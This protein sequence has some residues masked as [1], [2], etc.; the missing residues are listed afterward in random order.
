MHPRN[1][2]NKGYDFT[3]LIQALP[4]LANVTRANPKGRLT[5]DFANPH[6]IK[7][8][9]R[10]LLKHHYQI[11][12]WDI[13]EG[14]LCPPIPGRVDYIHAIADLI[15]HNDNKKQTVKGL[16]IGTGA[17]I[18]YPILGQQIYG[19][20]FVATDISEVAIRSA[21]HIQA[22]NKVLTKTIDIRRQAQNNQIFKGVLNKDER[23]TFSMCNPPFHASEA[24]AMAGSVQKNINLQKHQRKRQA[25]FA[26]DLKRAQKTDKQKLNFAGQSNELWC[27]GG[28]VGFIQ[29]M[30]N[31]SIE[32]QSQIKW[33]T[34]L[35]SKKESLKAIE[36]AITLTNA[37]DYKVIHMQQGSKQ[38]RIVAWCF[39]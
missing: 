1:I 19:W 26:A 24:A 31:E 5:I 12:F 36:K 11:D 23:F 39:H 16:D 9:N 37:V 25:Q 2:H 28:E 13:P 7:L 34:S 17:N 38:S 35:V 20:Q 14:N 21:R 29:R 22:A 30:I 10:A 27:K 32:Y 18:I 33:F 3:K 15:K 8:L 4:E 6:A